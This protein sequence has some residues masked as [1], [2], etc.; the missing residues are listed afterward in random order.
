MRIVEHETHSGR[1]A[2][3]LSLCLP[4]VLLI[5]GLGWNAAAQTPAKPTEQTASPAAKATVQPSAREQRDAQIAA[6]TERLY[7][8]AQELKA[9]LDKSTKDTLSLSVIRKADQVE[10]LAHSLKERLKTQ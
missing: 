5:S 6:D 7:Q 10:K 2:N 1:S 4:A 9:E 8:L 3:P